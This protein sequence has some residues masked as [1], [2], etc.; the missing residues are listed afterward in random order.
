VAEMNKLLIILVVFSLV[1]VLGGSMAY[2]DYLEVERFQANGV[3]KEAQWNTRNHK[4]SLFIIKEKYVEKKL[5]HFRVTLTPEQI[6][7]GDTFKK[8]KGAKFCEINGLKIKCV[9]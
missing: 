2:Y 4:M 8:D 9:E 1:I 7:V 3:V 6:K 5:H